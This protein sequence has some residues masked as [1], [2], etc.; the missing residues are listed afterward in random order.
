MV[1]NACYNTIIQRNGEA[2]FLRLH[3]E[4]VSAFIDLIVAL[5]LYILHPRSSPYALLSE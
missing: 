1:F 2:K 5:R 4:L 3:E